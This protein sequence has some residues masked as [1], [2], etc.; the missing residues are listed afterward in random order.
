M[1]VVLLK[2]LAAHMKDILVLQPIHWQDIASLRDLAARE[3]L[4]SVRVWRRKGA[5][6]RIAVRSSYT[7]S[8]KVRDNTL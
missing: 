4:P 6:K 2:N 8:L 1:I 3:N 5:R 7:D